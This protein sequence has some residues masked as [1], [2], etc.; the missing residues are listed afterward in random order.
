MNSRRIVNKRDCEFQGRSQLSKEKNIT[1]LKHFKLHCSIHAISISV[2]RPSASRSRSLP[3]PCQTT[4]TTTAVHL[5]LAQCANSGLVGANV[6]ITDSKQCLLRRHGLRLQ[7][8]LRPQRRTPP[9]P[10]FKVTLTL[11]AETS[12]KRMKPKTQ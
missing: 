3:C 1:Q 10:L 9:S 6:H 11:P 2:L 12:H 8:L 5:C 7:L 4:T